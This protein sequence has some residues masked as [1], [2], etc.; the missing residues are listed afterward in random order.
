MTVFSGWFL[1]VFFAVIQ[2]DA[3]WVWP[4]TYWPTS[5]L[6]FFSILRIILVNLE[7][8]WTELTSREPYHLIRFEV[9]EDRLRRVRVQLR[10]GQVN[11]GRW[12]LKFVIIRVTWWAGNCLVD[13]ILPN[14]YLKF[15][16]LT[17]SRQF[18][19]IR[20]CKKQKNLDANNI[21]D[22]VA[23]KNVN[24]LQLVL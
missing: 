21:I 7:Q 22:R 12:R 9:V 10:S 20:F 23:Y 1:A 14:E 11:I 3:T 16:L 5:R 2:I 18:D 15:K 8:G 24:V 4:L 6:G 17:V 19:L 13:Y